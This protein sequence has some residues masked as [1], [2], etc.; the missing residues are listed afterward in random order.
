MLQLIATVEEL[1]DENEE[2]DDVQVEIDSGHNV[3][4]W[5]Q[6]VVDHPSV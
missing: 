3:V 1:Q 5:S 6:A 2:V 4:V